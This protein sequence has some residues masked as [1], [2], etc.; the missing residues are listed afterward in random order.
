MSKAKLQSRLVGSW[1]EV[2][3]L[4]TTLKG[5]CLEYSICKTHGQF[6]VYWAEVECESCDMNE[7]GKDGNSFTFS[8]LDSVDNSKVNGFATI[9][10]IEGIG[11]HIDGYGDAHS[12]DEDSCPIY[13]DFYDN[14]LMVQIYG[15]IN[16]E[17]PTEVVSVEG[18]KLTKR[19]EHEEVA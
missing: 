9:E 7:E 18:A 8:L 17:E 3:D 13:I 2:E 14:K 6:M 16:S 1:K 5:A 15:D 4:S 19:I 12:K 10:S 11:I